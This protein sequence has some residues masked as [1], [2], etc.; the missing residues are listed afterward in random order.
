MYKMNT[1]E[2]ES[3]KEGT[4]RLKKGAGFTWGILILALCGVG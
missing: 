3:G 4:D 2:T 1:C